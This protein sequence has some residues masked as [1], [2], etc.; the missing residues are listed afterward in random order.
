MELYEKLKQR[1]LDKIKN[2]QDYVVSNVIKPITRS[3]TWTSSHLGCFRY[4]LNETDGH[5]NKK[6]ERFRYWRKRGAKVFTEIIMKGTTGKYDCRPDLLVV[7]KEGEVFVE[8][9][10]LTETLN[11]IEN[12][13][14]K[15]P[16]KIKV[17]KVER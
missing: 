15:Y 13:R 11:S 6:F 2:S 1:K 16:F 8:E 17:I 10:L 12:K 7:T 14:E 3:D 5:V 4:G 9:I